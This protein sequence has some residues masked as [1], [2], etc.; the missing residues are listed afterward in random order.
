MG[1]TAPLSPAGLLSL[2]RVWNKQQ[3]S[4]QGP[5]GNTRRPVKRNHL[6]YLPRAWPLFTSSCRHAT[7]RCCGHARCRRDCRLPIAQTLYG[8]NSEGMDRIVLHEFEFPPG[9]MLNSDESPESQHIWY[10]E[11]QR[12]GF[13]APTLKAMQ[14][15]A[16][17]R[18]WNENNINML[19]HVVHVRSV[20]V[21]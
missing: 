19:D 17:L 15:T 12:P 14:P 3:M 1:I 21:P 5:Q 20:V 8:S 6:S 4:N 18:G 13:A 16:T 7:R 9:L 10:S 11:Q 2:L